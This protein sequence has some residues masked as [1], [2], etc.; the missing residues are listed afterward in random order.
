MGSSPGGVGAV[1]V[2][3]NDK[4]VFCLSDIGS[5]NGQKVTDRCQPVGFLDAKSL[6]I[7]N[8]RCTACSSHCN[9]HDRHQIWKLCCTYCFAMEWNSISGDVIARVFSFDLSSHFSQHGDD[10]FISL[11]RIRIESSAGDIAAKCSCH[12]PESSVGPVAFD[13]QSS[14]FPINLIAGDLIADQVVFGT[15][16]RS[17]A[18]FRW[19]SFFQFL[20]SASFCLGNSFSDFTNLDP[21][22][23]QNLQCQI[24]IACRFQFCGQLQTA[25][26]TKKRQGE[27]ESSNKLGADISSQPIFA[28]LQSALDPADFRSDPSPRSRID[29]TARTACVCRIDS[30]R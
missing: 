22:L 20:R 11:C 26:A 9:S 7:G 12:Q 24:Y 15:G 5:K 13:F 16:I 6:C 27:Q 10:F 19:C 29:V 17:I 2:F 1:I 30:I 18:R 8:S 25:V 23:S 4:P 14:W 3:V 21:E 28:R